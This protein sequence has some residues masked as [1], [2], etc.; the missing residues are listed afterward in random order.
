MTVGGN[1][2]DTCGS[3]PACGDLVI[4]FQ[5]EDPTGYLDSFELELIYGDSG[6][7]PLV[8]SGA[9]PNGVITGGTLSAVAADFVGPTYAQAVAAGATRP[10][11]KGGHMQLTVPESSNPFPMIPCCYDTRLQAR[12]RTIV[13]CSS[14][15]MYYNE[16]DYT[17][18]ITV[19]APEIIER[20]PGSLGV[21][22]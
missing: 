9:G 4:E 22:V 21:G 2:A 15:D 20:E 12:T 10:T 3:L 1:V 8:G 5:V 6:A 19:C 7:V 13:D 17:I 14:D 11:W 18:G 16:S